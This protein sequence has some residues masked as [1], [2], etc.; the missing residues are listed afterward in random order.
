MVGPGTR[1]R[2]IRRPLRLLFILPGVATMI[3]CSGD[4]DPVPGA[5]AP[6]TAD[7]T[8][9]AF[10]DQSFSVGQEFWHGGFVVA[11]GDGLSYAVENSG[12]FD[13]EPRYFVS[14][15]ASFENLGEDAA[16]FGA[17]TVLSTGG[18]LFELSFES[19]LPTV[20]G[21]LSGEGSL[22]FEVEEG[23][24]VGGAA[25]LV[26]SGGERRSEVPLDPAAGELVTV[27]PREVEISGELSLELLD[28]EVTSG[29]V[30][31]DRPV[32]HTQVGE[33]ELAL[34]LDFDAVSRND[35]NWTIRAED[36]ALSL[37]GG[38][39][40]V[41]EGAG[42]E[43]LPGSDEG[44]RTDGMYLRFLI[45]DPAEGDYELRFTAPS[46]FVGDDDLAE[47]TLAFTM[48]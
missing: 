9:A 27:E 37:P 2:P 44:I 10:E 13:D 38:S 14:L 16:S 34:T 17:E 39:S 35:G 20:P 42:L 41:P 45:D 36:F 30:R 29:E 43:T 6:S 15:E 47:A 7:T 4:D 21:G 40:V 28:L 8:G 31:A 23:V 33:G 1:P 24:D 11:L 18:E 25:L 19:E 5:Q 46:W 26:G 22:V 3:G 48:S 12:V 32:D